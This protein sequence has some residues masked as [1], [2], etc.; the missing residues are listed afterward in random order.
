MMLR[1]ATFPIPGAVDG[2]AGERIAWWLLH[3]PAQLRDGPHAGAVAGALDAQMRPDYAY[4]ESTGYFLQWLA[5][6]ARRNGDVARLAPRAQAAQAWLGRWLKS[7]PL[8]TRVPL[9]AARDD[10]RNRTSFT[11]DLAMALRGLG[12]AAA[13]KLLRPEPA[14]V[15]GL[16]LQLS[17]LVRE[18]GLFDACLT[19]RDNPLPA[20]WSTR[21]G[22][23]LAKAAAGI[24]RAGGQLSE[25]P[26][27]VLQAARTTFSAALRWAVNAPH[28]DVHPLLYSYEGMLILAGH[29]EVRPILPRL[30]AGFDALLQEMQQVGSVAETHGLPVGLQRTDV[31]AQVVRMGDLLGKRTGGRAVSSVALAHLRQRLVEA[32]RPDGAVPFA[33]GSEPSLSNVWAAMFASQALEGMYFPGLGANDDPLLV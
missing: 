10:W 31:L 23:F 17:R 20:R 4:P 24:L 27:D 6:R 7:D 3:G 15:R 8:L 26:D 25:I 21:R 12:A 9:G 22:G 1:T 16:S 13:G 32:I 18:D 5:W 19:P 33:L 11:F 14:V 28:D 2:M 30:N 29:E